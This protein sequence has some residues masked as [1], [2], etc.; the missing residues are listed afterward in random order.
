MM[1]AG[2]GND[3]DGD[4]GGVLL[5]TASGVAVTCYVGASL[6]LVHRALRLG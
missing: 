2:D 1:G 3:D 4:D 5:I 6:E